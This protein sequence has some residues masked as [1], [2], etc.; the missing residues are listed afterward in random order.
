MSLTRRQ[1]AEQ[2]NPE[3][4]QQYDEAM[5][6]GAQATNP[7][8]VQ[9][10]DGKEKWTFKDNP[11][12]TTE[13][14]QKREWAIDRGQALMQVSYTSVEE[15]E[16]ALMRVYTGAS[17]L[18]RE[19]MLAVAKVC[20][21]GGFHPLPA[22]GEVHAWYDKERVKNDKGV[23]ED[24][25]FLIIYL[26]VKGRLRKARLA[27]NFTMGFELIQ[28]DQHRIYGIPSHKLAVMGKL[29]TEE[30]HA[31][32]MPPITAIGT[33]NLEDSTETKW[34]FSAEEKKKIEV[35]V[36]RKETAWKGHTPYDIAVK[37]AQSLL[38]D[39]LGVGRGM[40]PIPASTGNRI[41]LPIDEEVTIT[42]PSEFD[43]IGEPVWESQSE[44]PIDQIEGEPVI[45]HDTRVFLN[46]RMNTHIQAEGAT[47]T[48]NSEVTQNI[49]AI[50]KP[51]VK[52]MGMSDEHRRDFLQD[53]F[54]WRSVA[55]LSNAQG[56]A[57]LDWLHSPREHVKEV[58][59]W[60]IV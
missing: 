14:R 9:D 7:R 15:I 16:E 3:A 27:Y 55:E 52:E 34:V 26:G 11:L 36:E 57:L 29:Q 32:G 40:L 4:M 23:W 51:L 31:Q 50:M 6:E 1:K 45:V 25:Y 39:R 60:Y 46:E 12:D 33:F 2:D 42:R 49:Q 18:R 56:H 10:A 5:K 58:L 8:L 21:D 19:D 17:T 37:R 30:G 38:V 20:F 22:Y 43:E 54:T 47:D 44:P 48:I 41:M 24:Q 13:Q 28:P 35:P 59:G 53:M